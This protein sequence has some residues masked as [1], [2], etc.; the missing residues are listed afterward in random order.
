MQASRTNNI[1]AGFKINARVVIELGNKRDTF[2]RFKVNMQTTATG[3]NHKTTIC[4]VIVRHGFVRLKTAVARV[5]VNDQ[6][7]G[8]QNAITSFKVPHGLH[9]LKLIVRPIWRVLPIAGPRFFIFLLWRQLAAVMVSVTK[10]AKNFKARIYV[11]PLVSHCFY[12][13]DNR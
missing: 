9:Q 5:Y 3:T 10:Q 11:V 12:L 2:R 6:I 8:H 7:T 1:A 4:L 13:P